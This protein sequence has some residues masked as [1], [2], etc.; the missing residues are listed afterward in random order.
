M[1]DKE[2]KNATLSI[3]P[4]T[5]YIIIAVV[6]IAILVGVY[7]YRVSKVRNEEKILNSYLLTTDTVSL[8][9][10]NL[11]EINQILSEAPAQYFV[12]ITYTGDEGTYE[13]EK[14]IKDIIDEYKLSDSFYYLNVKDIMNQDNYITRINSAFNTNEITKV[15]TILYFQDNELEYVVER[16]DD[17]MINA[18]DFQKVLDI[19]G[20]EGQ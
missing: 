12:L 7:I 9:I 2:I 1:N 20:Y 17:N 15:P 11:D 4:R 18:G 8:E 3:S 6:L 10:K 19:Y 5:I 16:I 13:L 14:S